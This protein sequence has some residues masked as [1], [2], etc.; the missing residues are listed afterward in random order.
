MRV[1]RGL[2]GL[3]RSLW[4]QAG[5]SFLSLVV[6]CDTRCTNVMSLQDIIGIAICVLAMLP[7][8]AHFRFFVASLIFAHRHFTSQEFIYLNRNGMFSFSLAR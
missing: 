1:D 6:V 4:T 2:S 7:A 5:L 3:A 8:S